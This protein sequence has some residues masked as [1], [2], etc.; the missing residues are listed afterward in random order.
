M[1]L[2]PDLHT[3][4]PPYCAIRAQRC[5]S[6]SA[7][8]GQACRC[9]SLHARQPRSDTEA[10]LAPMGILVSTIPIILCRTA[11]VSCIYLSLLSTAIG[12][13]PLLRPPS[14]NASAPQ[15]AAQE[16]THTLKC[17][18]CQQRGKHGHKGQWRLSML[19]NTPI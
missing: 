2:V 9:Q 12:Q 7:Y 16:L 1:L 17:P 6:T 18:Q 13:T 11:V 14:H 3:V 4:P 8:P 10:D 19:G 5:V 15:R